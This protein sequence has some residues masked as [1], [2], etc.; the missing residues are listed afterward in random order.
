MNSK[1]IVR[2]TFYTKYGK[3]CLD[4]LLALGAIIVLA[5]VILLIAILV[6]CKLG[7]PIIFHQNRPGYHEKVFRMIKFRSMTD[8][9]ESNGELLSD[10]ARLTLF[11]SKLRSTSLDELPELWNIIKGDMSIVGPRPLLVHYLPLYNERQKHRHDVRPGFTGYAQI[12]GRNNI[13]W[14]EKF[15]LDVW[16]VQNVSLWLDIK[17]I[18][19][20]IIIVIKREGI[21]SKNSATTEIFKGSEE[22][23]KIND[24]RC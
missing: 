23:E 12:N 17:I 4:V 18:F 9:R 22:L 10:E 20:T 3:R 1:N 5:P 13:T 14:K 8:K 16:Y 15:E 6:R 21:S 19:K 2:Q 7:S 11:G 24:N